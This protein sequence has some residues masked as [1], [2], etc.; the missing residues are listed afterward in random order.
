MSTTCNQ[1]PCVALIS[2]T[3]HYDIILH[4]DLRLIFTILSIALIMYRRM[5][6]LAKKELQIVWKEAIVA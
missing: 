5:I 2:N 6:E 3:Y 1:V 4:R